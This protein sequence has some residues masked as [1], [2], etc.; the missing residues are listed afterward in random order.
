MTLPSRH[1]PLVHLLS[2]LAAL[3]TLLA[4]F[5][6]AF[7]TL[8]YQWNW[9]ALQPYWPKLLQ[10]WWITLLLSSCAML[11]SLLIGL[12][13]ALAYRQSFLPL[14]Y[15]VLIYTNLIRGTPLLVQILIFYYVIADALGL[16]NRYAAGILILSLFHGAYLS[17]IIRA[18]IESISASQR[19]SARAI[20]LNSYQTYRYI[21]FPQALRQALPP[22]AGQFAS[23]IKDS[24]LLSIISITEFTLSAQETNA[25]TYSTLESYL[26]LALGYLVITLPILWCS[27]L[28]EKK[29]AY[30]T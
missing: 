29:F 15:L 17:E 18:G 5:Y 22:M 23:L 8:D 21:V 14:R 24:S 27:H 13:A 26:P 9:A 19:E 3:A 16:D 30:E 4:F 6:H 11:L 12:L 25:F 2:F 20:G 28:L 1:S 10:G 7:Q